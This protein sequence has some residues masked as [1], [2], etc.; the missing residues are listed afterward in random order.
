MRPV[1]W[2][3]NG[4]V[5]APLLFS[6]D[7]LNQRLVVQA[8]V[9]TILFCL[10]ASIGYIINDIHD[11]ASDRQ[12]ADKCRHRPLAS[13]Q[14]TL[15]QAL[16]LLGI[17]SSVFLSAAYYYK[18]P[19][20]ATVLAYVLLQL[21]YTFYLKKHA[22]IDIFTIACGFVMRVYAGAAAI[23]VPVSS[24]MFITTLC[25]ALYL[26]ALKRRQE[27]YLHGKEARLALLD[28][29][30]TFI[31]VCAMVSA[32]GALVFYGLFVMSLKPNL[33]W[34]IPVVFFALLRY[35]F[36]VEHYSLGESPLEAVWRDKPLAVAIIIWLVMVICNMY[37]LH[38][39]IQII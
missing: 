16:W 15:R 3:K 10:A 12:H 4:F 17:L 19:G 36:I 29:H 27:I 6:G 18:I 38:S 30:H 39:Q 8:C 11:R 20:V 13:G 9:M 1:H 23:A 32:S 31:E 37:L 22:L 34:T 28:Y 5:L 14:V 21:A 35:W 26:A 33:E 2:L 7:F 25:L 24:W